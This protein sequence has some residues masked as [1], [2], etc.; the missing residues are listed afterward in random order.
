MHGDN[1]AIIKQTVCIMFHVCMS[2]FVRVCMCVCLREKERNTLEYMQY[3]AVSL[4]LQK[5]RFFGSVI[6]SLQ[7]LKDF[8]LVN[9]R[10]CVRMRVCMRARLRAREHLQVCVNMCVCVC[11]CVH[12]H[13]CV[14]MCV[15]MWVC[16]CM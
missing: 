10:V 15:R 1:P 2:V 8:S 6:E 9:V 5:K 16:M 14:C 12:S 7:R 3:M 13:V 11:M 4:Q